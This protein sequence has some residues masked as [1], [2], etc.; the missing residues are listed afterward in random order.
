MDD[1][2]YSDR[3]RWLALTRIN[4]LS[5]LSQI[6]QIGT[7]TPLLS[8]SLEQKG[9]DPAKIGVI[10]SASWIA[11][12]LLYKVVPR[13]L[14]HLGHLGLVKANLLSVTLAVI[15]AGDRV[16]EHQVS[17]AMTAIALFYTLGSVL[18]PIATGATV[19]YVSPHGLMISVGV[20]GGLFI[21]LLMLRR[22]P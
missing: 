11:I 20:A 13:L 1:I 15:E 22:I 18:G 6:V 12:L 5:V 2:A 16:A 17:T 19:S 10:V 4:T 14:G 9:V 7:I 21:A 8:L 3:Q